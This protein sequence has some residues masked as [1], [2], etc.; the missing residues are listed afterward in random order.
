MTQ[1]AV[2]LCCTLYHNCLQALPCWRMH[3]SYHTRSCHLGEQGI[4]SKM[5]TCNQ[6]HICS[7]ILTCSK[8]ITYSN[9]RG[10]HPEHQP[11][12]C[13]LTAAN[14]SLAHCCCCRALAEP[15]GQWMMPQAGTPTPVGAL[16]RRHDIE[17]RRTIQADYHTAEADYITMR[18]E[19]YD[20]DQAHRRRKAALRQADAIESAHTIHSASV[21]QTEAAR[22]KEMMAMAQRQVVQLP[23]V[24]FMADFNCMQQR[25]QQQQYD[26]M[27]ATQMLLNEAASPLVHRRGSVPSA[28]HMAG[29][30]VER[31]QH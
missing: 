25:Q 28:G 29:H 30:T 2:H 15:T 23:A 13:L 18:T 5:C 24:P 12:A 22:H 7:K 27:V 19:A 14:T 17:G 16:A 3:L 10:V 21:Q 11:I 9:S 1:Q 8:T 31:V 26:E 6:T 20:L 4:C